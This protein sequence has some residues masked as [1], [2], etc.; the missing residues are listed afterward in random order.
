ML[1]KSAPT[2]DKLMIQ[3][4]MGPTPNALQNSLLNAQQFRLRMS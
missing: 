3:S 2:V 1:R 4:G